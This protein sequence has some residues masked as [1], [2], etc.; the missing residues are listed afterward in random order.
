MTPKRKET[1]KPENRGTAP[2]APARERANAPRIIGGMLGGRRLLYG[3]PDGRTRP[4]KDRVREA[5]FNLLGPDVAGTHAIDLFA[6]TG[7]MGF[8]AIS[9]GAARATLIEQ[10]FPTAAVIRQN[11]AE[12]GVVDRVEVLAANAFVWAQ[13]PT[14]DDSL[15]WLVF[16]CPPYVFYQDRRE[17]MLWLAQSLIERSPA[18]S[19]FVAECDKRFDVASLPDG[20]DWS[21]R[22]YLPAVIAIYR[23]S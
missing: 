22:E 3:G 11:A 2:R 19:T 12:L 23:K 13:Q 8:E 15:P 20:A 9:R 18:G 17:Q 16:C 21:V 6:G 7:A 10:H 5:V 1:R 14:V 4:M